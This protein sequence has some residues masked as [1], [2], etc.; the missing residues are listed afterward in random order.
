MALIEKLNAIGDAI[1]AKTGGTEKLTLDQMPSEIKSIETTSAGGVPSSALTLTGNSNY[2]FANGCW[3]W[4][5]EQYGNQIT[6]E[7]IIYPGYMFY[8][9]MSLTEIPFDINLRA[10]NSSTYV[11]G[12]GIAYNMFGECYKLTTLPKLIGD[13]CNVENMFF[14]CYNLNIIPSEFYKNINFR[15]IDSSTIICSGLFEKCYSLREVPMAM[16]ENI[17][18]NSNSQLSGYQSFFTNCYS[19]NAI[20]GLPVQTSSSSFSYTFDSCSRLKS[21]T[22]AKQ[23]S[24]TPYTAEWSGRTIDLSKYVGYVNSSYTKY[25]TDYNSGITASKRVTNNITYNSLSSDADWWTSDVAYSR[26]NKTSAIATINSL[27]DTS[28]YATTANTIKFKGEAGSATDGGAINTM[29]EKQI[30]VA[31]AKGWTVAFV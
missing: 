29:T 15:I 1:R 20:Q 5:I 9:C 24:G 22:F 19:L 25:I 7:N 26:Y 16:L 17:Y 18:A 2:R 21:M 4:F 3:D 31:T 12:L 14:S 11:S 6:T 13:V 10:Y 30:A 23:A 27:P 8:N 28:D